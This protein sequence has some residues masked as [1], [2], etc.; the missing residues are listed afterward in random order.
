M[1]EGITKTDLMENKKF[2]EELMAYFPWY[3]PGHIE[4][5]ASNISSV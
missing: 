4:N 2:W 5:D 3:D 1:C